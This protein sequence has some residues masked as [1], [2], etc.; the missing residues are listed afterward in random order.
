MDRLNL[1]INYSNDLQEGQLAGSD[2]RSTN[3]G[4]GFTYCP[5]RS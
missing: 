4:L 5:G 3:V 2:S 1:S